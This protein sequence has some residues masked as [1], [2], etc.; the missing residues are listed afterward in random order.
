MSIYGILGW[1]ILRAKDIRRSR[2]T[3]AEH[4]RRFVNKCIVPHLHPVVDTDT[5]F[6]CV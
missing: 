6:H 1:K 4:F 2:G 3:S 5:P